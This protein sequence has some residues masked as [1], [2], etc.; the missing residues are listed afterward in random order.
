MA[1]WWLYRTEEEEQEAKADDFS[2]LAEQIRNRADSDLMTRTGAGILGNLYS[3][4]EKGLSFMDEQRQQAQESAQQAASSFGDWATDRL[5]DANQSGVDALN[6]GG[7]QL[8]ESAAQFGDWAQDRLREQMDKPIP[9]P[10]SAM[11]SL[12]P[13][14]IGRSVQHEFERHEVPQAWQE[15]GNDLATRPFVGDR[16]ASSTQKLMKPVAKTM[17][18]ASDAANQVIQGAFGGDET[19]TVTNPLGIKDTPI[20]PIGEFLGVEEGAKFGVGDVIANVAPTRTLQAVQN[21]A[22]GG[23][24]IDPSLGPLEKAAAVAAPFAPVV[25]GKVIRYAGSRVGKALE[26]LG[27]RPKGEAPTPQVADSAALRT[28][29][30]QADASWNAP[31]TA[32]EMLPEPQL[33]GTPGGQDEGLLTRGM[34]AIGMEAPT[35]NVVSDLGDIPRTAQSDTSI[36]HPSRGGLAVG[37]QFQPGT[38]EHTVATTLRRSAEA[39]PDGLAHLSGDEISN[40]PGMPIPDAPEPKQAVDKNGNLRFTKKGKPVMTVDYRGTPPDLDDLRMAVDVGLPHSL[41]YNDFGRWA[42]DTLGAANIDEFRTLFGI[43]SAQT[44]VDENFIYTMIAMRKARELA[45]QGKLADRDAWEQAFR[46]ARWLSADGKRE[47]KVKMTGSQIDKIYQGYNEGQVLNTSAA[48]TSSYGGNIAS[49]SRNEYDPNTTMDVWMFQLMGWVNSFAP[50]QSDESYRATHALFDHL[51]REKGINPNQ[52]QAAAW[53]ALKQMSDVTPSIRARVNRGEISLAEGLRLARQAG[54]YDAANVKADFSGTLNA[55]GARQWLTLAQEVLDPNV[56]G[57]GRAADMAL[58]YPGDKRKKVPYPRRP[59]T[60]EW[61]AEGQGN[62]LREAPRIAVP[63]SVQGPIPGLEAVPHRVEDLGA[64]SNVYLPGGNTNTALYAASAV[65]R[66][67]DA[68]AVAV[69]VPASTAQTVGGVR[70]VSPDGVQLTPEQLRPAVQQLREQGLDVFVDPG[71]TS[72]TL[73]LPEGAS[74]DT[75]RAFIESA[76]RAAVSL[77]LTPDAVYGWAGD[78]HR[79]G[80]SDYARNIETLGRTY[81]TE[82]RPSLSIGSD[83]RGVSPQEQRSPNRVGSALRALGVEGPQAGI[84]GDAGRQ[85]D[86]YYHGTGADFKRLK[87]GDGIR[88]QGVYLTPDP[89]DAAHYAGIGVKDGV[90]PNIRPI[91][92]PRNL[93]L[94]DTASDEFQRISNDVWNDRSLGFGNKDSIVNRKL[95]EQGYDGLR[96]GQNLVIFPESLDKIRNATAGTP[97]GL[98]PGAP[99]ANLGAAG[100]QAAQGAAQG[101]ISGGIAASQD[102][103]ASPESIARGALQGAGMGLA[104]RAIRAGL[105]GLRNAELRGTMRALQNY[106][107]ADSTIAGSITPPPQP[108]SSTIRDLPDTIIRQLFDNTVPLKRVA[109]AVERLRG[110]KLNFGESA[111]NLMRLSRGSAAAAEQAIEENLGPVLKG[112]SDQQVFDLNK[113]LKAMDIIDK[114]AV[115]PGHNF[116]GATVND[117]LQQI[118]E[119]Q[120]ALDPAEWTAIQD[121]AQQVWSFGHDLLARKLDA[122]LIDQAMYADLVNRFPHYSPIRIIDWLDDAMQ[123]GQ[124][125]MGPSQRLNSRS[126]GIQQLTDYGTDRAAETPLDAYVRL[127]HETYRRSMINEAA[128]AMVMHLRE[129]GRSSPEWKSMITPAN[130]NAAIM[131]GYGKG[132][133]RR[134]PGQVPFAA[135]LNGER[136]DFYL[137][138]SMEQAINFVGPDMKKNWAT[139]LLFAMPADALRAGATARNVLFLIPNAM[140]DFMTYFIRNGGLATMGETLPAYA[141]G[142][143]SALTKDQAYHDLRMAGGGY[144]GFFGAE[145]GAGNKT[146]N[147]LRG[148][149]TNDQQLRQ[150]VMS[151]LNAVPRAGERVESATR[152]AEF[153]RMRGRGAGNQE[154]ALAARDVTIDF[155][156]GGEFTK[157]ANAFIPFFNVG[158]QAPAQIGRALF[159]PTTAPKAW[160]GL[161]STVIIPTI[162]LE[163][164]NRQFKEYEDV[165]QYDKDRGLIIMDPRGSTGKINP[166]TGRVTPRY[167][168]L[169]LREWSPFA[170]AVREAM[171]RTIYNEPNRDP[172]EVAYAVLK[173]VSPIDPPTTPNLTPSVESFGKMALDVMPPAFRVGAELAGNYDRFRDRQI[174]PDA[175]KRL[176]NDQQYTSDTS[177][178]AKLLGRISGQSPLMIQHAVTGLGAGVGKQIL[179]AGDM[180][181]QATG[182]TEPP[183][184]RVERLQRDLAKSGLS[185]EKRVVLQHELD[186]EQA[187]QQNRESSVKAIPVVGGLASTVY[188]EQGGEIERRTGKQIDERL[189]QLQSKDD[190]TGK[191][192]SRLGVT[193]SDVEREIAGRQL[194]RYQYEQYRSTALAYREQALSDLMASPLY[195]GSDDATRTR[196]ARNVLTRAA[197]W[198]SQEVLP[199]VN[200]SGREFLTVADRD[201]A[202]ASQGYLSAL[203]AQQSLA[204][205]KDIRY[206]GYN[207]SEAEEI[208]QDRSYLSAFRQQFGDA[209]GDSIFLA[210][211]GVRRYARAKAAKVNPLYT[212]QVDQ[213]ERSSPALYTYLRQNPTTTDVPLSV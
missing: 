126:T 88:G 165:P 29:I 202:T 207:G 34:R 176:P 74:D 158:F 145:A 89:K 16:E 13:N 50:Q 48:K 99:T 12:S 100:R 179:G 188:R 117:A 211:Y 72:L 177:E 142:W 200:P 166:E 92:V 187:K 131:M 160:A 147:E 167:V 134:A 103:D 18:A 81:G 35:S 199:G 146:V 27:E 10:G 213:I 49:G 94:I 127:A 51:A 4:A 133:I 33:R 205:L 135:Y 28:D 31:E 123:G 190:P 168:P 67:V 54:A 102:E 95:S 162:G 138:K 136:F 130:E 59:V 128:S 32:G 55:P 164:Y 84:A 212:R 17:G 104:N 19:R 60:P 98:L 193:F 121:R 181:M 61:T 85:Y 97:G 75:A 155:S 137:D 71:R 113:Y 44:K 163:A 70:I 57:P 125:T 86:R 185:E 148:A 182:G 159:N 196:L 62:A 132:Q 52:A 174:V 69:H 24:M 204:D 194:N 152:L 197:A 45:A 172:R 170:I 198:A 144:A 109:D 120:R 186:V 9:L 6:S 41:W 108:S 42:S 180:L 105:P 3:A 15:F 77:G 63:G 101:A 79:V 124:R 192:L 116:G 87:P 201:I 23:P 203:Q 151:V 171:A 22:M 175:L 37:E 143:K 68:D 156:R 40:L 118:Q 183:T 65:G 20:R 76:N 80:R 14:E 46:N 73:A 64:T 90:G 178:S 149:V 93:N 173:A 122:G 107:P 7:R 115:S 26:A 53:F 210:R 119:M 66:H 8:G 36:A 82:R 21:I 184:R 208:A 5:K 38:P 56:P 106:G 169:N 43:T 78:I 114:D 154:A 1:N 39:S 47:N 58:V 25:A 111:Y 189:K 150:M 139:N 129:L 91:D 157:W 83:A 153:H 2:R 112:L 140:G 161:V 96:D 30:P 141:K 191:E 195:E 110:S 209:Q 11:P 206:Q